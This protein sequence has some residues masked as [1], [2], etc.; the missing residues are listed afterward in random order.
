MHDRSA[1]ADNVTVGD[2]GLSALVMPLQAK[3]EQKSSIGSG[4]PWPTKTN[5]CLKNARLND[6]GYA[7]DSDATRPRV[8]VG[9]ALL[10]HA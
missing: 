7:F 3:S 4:V 6:I 10:P 5:L 8:A 1:R 2:P 9:P